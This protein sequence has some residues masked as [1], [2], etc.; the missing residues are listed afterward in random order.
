LIVFQN[1]DDRRL[2]VERFSIDPIKTRIVNGSGVNTTRYPV[3]PLPDEPVFLLVARLLG[4]KGVREYASAAKLVQQKFP[5]VR[6]QIAGWIDENPFSIRQDELDD[7]CRS[8][9]IEYLGKLDDVRPAIAS[10]S[11]FVLPSFYGE[12]VPRTILEAMSM[13]RPII[14]TDSPGCRETVVPG[15]NGFLVATRSVEPL[16]EAMLKLIENPELRSSMGRA[17]RKLAEE[18]FDVHKVNESLYSY[19][20]QDSQ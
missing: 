11:T 18:K 7:W 1:P 17:S 15:K 16:A 3:Q 4:D 14:T 5:K 10:C 19:L 2:I 6:F 12:G 9:T 8:G 13:G 20:F